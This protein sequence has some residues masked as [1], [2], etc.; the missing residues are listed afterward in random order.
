MFIDQNIL[1]QVQNKQI[2]TGKAV[3]LLRVSVEEEV[4]K[5]LVKQ[6]EEFRKVIQGKH[7]TKIRY[8]LRSAR[9]KQHKF[10]SHDYKNYP[11]DCCGAPYQ[12]G[13]KTCLEYKVVQALTDI[14][15]E[16]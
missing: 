2:S 3:E 1:I 4:K 7:F 10:T 5:A 11:C 8:I 15:K 6:R 13:T 14:L 12:S 16:L 9:R